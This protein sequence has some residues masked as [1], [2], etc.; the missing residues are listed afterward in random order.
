LPPGLLP[1]VAT[2]ERLSRDTLM[3][4]TYQD[5]AAGSLFSQQTRNIYMVNVAQ[6]DRLQRHLERLM[7]GKQQALTEPLIAQLVSL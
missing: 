2:R 3:S 4:Q 7:Q 1:D 6:R 5:L